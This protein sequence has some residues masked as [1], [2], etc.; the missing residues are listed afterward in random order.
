M[1][2]VDCGPV[3]NGDNDYDNEGATVVDFNC[4]ENKPCAIVGGIGLGTGR[5]R[6]GLKNYC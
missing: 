1:D 6:T 4:F 5:L 3:E 2:E